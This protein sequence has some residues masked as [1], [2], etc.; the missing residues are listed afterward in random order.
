MKPENKHP[1]SIL[2][3]CAAFAW[4]SACASQWTSAK[5][6]NVGK[7]EALIQH[8]MPENILHLLRPLLCVG[9]VSDRGQVQSVY[10]FTMNGT[11]TDGFERVVRFAVMRSRLAPAKVGGVPRTVLMPFSVVYAD[12]RFRISYYH[13]APEENPHGYSAPQMYAWGRQWGTFACQS[14]K[15]VWMSVHISKTGRGMRSR[16]LDENDPSI[17]C[18]EELSDVIGHGRFIPAMQDGTPV[19]GDFLGA[20]NWSR[21]YKARLCS[22]TCVTR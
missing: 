10:C 11:N 19:E 2:L 3:A 21:S 6:E 9:E 12:G 4:N 17:G 16:F 13:T 5:F 22:S 7:V 1:C 8:Y 18:K 20:W 15:D 14:P